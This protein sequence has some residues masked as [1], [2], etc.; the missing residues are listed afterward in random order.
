VKRERVIEIA[1]YG[2][3]F[4]AMWIISPWMGKLLDRLYY[5]YPGLFSDSLLLLLAGG[6]VVLSG[7][8]L[9]MWTIVVFKTI[10]K[11]TPNPKVPPT[12]LVISG[13]YH[14]CRNP[15][16]FGGFLFLLGEAGIYQSP[17]LAG[18]SVLFAIVLYL[19]TVY[20][21]EP[22]LRKRFGRPYERYCKTTPRFIP[23]QFRRYKG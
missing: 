3:V 16:A 8:S 1:T 11:G 19:N 5:P 10:G 23:N 4:L 18:L 12:E 2:M 7:L 14:Y 6:L 15:M 9:V 22:E 20:V 17:S 13:P 21:E